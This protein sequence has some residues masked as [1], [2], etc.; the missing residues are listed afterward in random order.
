[1][2]SA[3]LETMKEKGVSDGDVVTPWKVLRC[4]RDQFTCKFTGLVKVIRLDYLFL[5][6]T[7]K[8]KG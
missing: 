7:K 1:M 3:K 5:S 6:M 4:P 2:E 8:T